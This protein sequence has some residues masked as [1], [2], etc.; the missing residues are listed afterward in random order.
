M[1]HKR[2]LGVYLSYNNAT[3]ALLSGSGHKLT[4]HKAFTVSADPDL[5]SQDRIKSLISQLARNISDMGLKFEEMAVSLDCAMFAQHNLHSEFTDHK[6]IASTIAFDAEE[7]VATDATE[8]A[9][10]FNITG[11]NKIGS[12]VTVFTAK[13][14]VLANVLDELKTVN[15]DPI[16]VEPDMVCL[17]RYLSQNLASKMTPET[18]TVIMAPGIC[19]LISPAK[20]GFSPAIRSFLVYPNQD[21]I[22]L[23]ARQIPI[24]IASHAPQTETPIT[25]LLIAGSIDNI[26]TAALGEMTGFTVQT[27][28]LISDQSIDD[29]NTS[30][31]A[32]A[33]AYGTAMA[34]LIK[35]DTSD[36]RREFMPFQGKKRILQ[37]SIRTLTMYLTI[38]MIAVG[39]YFQAKIYKK[40]DAVATLNEQAEQT[41]SDV[42]Y[43]KK[44]NTKHMSIVS[45]LR[46]EA[47]KVKKAGSGLGVGD[48]RSVSA[49]L[50]YLL[51]AINGLPKSV[52]LT[53]KDIK[54]TARDITVIGHT[55]SRSSYG[56]L[57]KAIGNHKKLAKGKE[58][59]KQASGTGD[60]F[61]ISA[62]LK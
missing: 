36:F 30:T 9:V 25:N 53:I 56:K 49:K 10:T 4:L 27:S 33:I 3:A 57:S 24:T 35:T 60:S 19:Y 59:F 45:Q 31:A 34:E 17:S 48:E 61:T 28:D 46:T 13:R 22:P 32:V 55:N 29:S 51:Q 44:A 8:L 52:K 47:N 62:K 6:Q 7:A 1:E 16:I 20:H 15:L 21:I 38:L 54:I 23:L 50:T 39:I 11:T 41:F 2:C 18:L 58:N 5:D 43:G 42:M 26:D 40:T 12:N 37:K 14:D